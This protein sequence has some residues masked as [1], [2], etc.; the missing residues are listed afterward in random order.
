MV[1]LPSGGV[2]L[3]PVEAIKPGPGGIS[4]HVEEADPAHEDMALVDPPV[5]EAKLPEVAV[6]EPRR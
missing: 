6:V 1:V 2:E 3:R 5:V 4:R